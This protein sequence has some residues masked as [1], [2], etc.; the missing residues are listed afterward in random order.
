MSLVNL[1]RSRL[2]SAHRLA[3]ALPA[4]TVAQYSKQSTPP[5]LGILFVP[6][7]EAWVVERMGKFHTILNPVRDDNIFALISFLID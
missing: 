3:R 2:L 7:Q 1:A 4:L 6:Q 5:N